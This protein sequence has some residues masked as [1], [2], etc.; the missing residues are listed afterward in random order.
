MPVCVIYM[1][2]YMYVY[3]TYMYMEIH[4][5]SILAR[6]RFIGVHVRMLIGQVGHLII[7]T[8]EARMV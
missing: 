1:Y 7:H 4:V 6:Y 2:M 5:F 8:T 3:Y